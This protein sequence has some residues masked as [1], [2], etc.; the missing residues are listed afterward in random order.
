[1]TLHTLDILL[2]SQHLLLSWEL[3]QTMAF[4]KT[5]SSLKAEHCRL[6]SPKEET[7][8]PIPLLMPI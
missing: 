8:S 5:P 6:L 1:M 2:A 7:S 3:Y 4:T